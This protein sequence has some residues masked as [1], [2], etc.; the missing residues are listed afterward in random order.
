MVTTRNDGRKLAAVFHARD[1]DAVKNMVCSG[2]SFT[3]EAKTVPSCQKVMI[4]VFWDEDGLILVDYLPK[5]ATINSGYFCKLVNEDLRHQL[6]NRRRGKLSRKPIFQM[7]NA[8]PHTAARTKDLLEK[9]GWD[10]LPHP[11]YS[12]DLA[13]SDFHLFPRLKEPLRGRRFSS[14]DEMKEAVESW[15]Q[16]TPKEFYQ[17]GLRSLVSRWRK[18]VSSGGDYIEKLR[19][20]SE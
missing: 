4:S 14:L 12:P 7:D 3:F 17:G 20:D 19:D 1:E 8:T 9:L 18:C 13:P 16:S 6:K 5:G 11:P 2:R 15:R 10:V